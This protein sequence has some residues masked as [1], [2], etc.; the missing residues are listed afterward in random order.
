MSPA[1][2]LAMANVSPPRVV[3]V[4]PHDPAST[5]ATAVRAPKAPVI[6]GRADEAIWATAQVI[7]GFRVYDPSEDG[8][9]RFNTEARVA[10]DERNIYIVVRAF[11]PHPDS[12]G[13]LLSR[14]D[15]RTASDEIKV[16]IDSYHD[17][18][19]GF[20]F[21][22]NPA[23]VKRDIAIFNDSE[24]DVSW[25]AVWDA[26][27]HVDSQGWVAEFRI[28]L[29]QLRYAAKP[30]HTFGLAIAR[31]VARDNESYA[32][33]VYRRSKAGIASQFGELQGITGIASPRRL[34]VA[35]YTVAKTANVPN[36]P[37]AYQQRSVGTVGA[38]IKYGLTSNLTIDATVNPDFGQ[39]EADPSVLNLSAFESFFPEKRPFFLEGQGLFRFDMNCNDGQCSGMFYSRRIGRAPQLNDQYF[40]DANPTSTT[41]LGAGKLTGRLSNGMSVG[42]LNAVTQREVAP[43][44]KT[45]EP[46]AN[47][48]VGRVQQ[49]L[50]G[51]KSVVGIMATN[52]HRDQDPWTSDLL[53]SDATAI[54]IDTRHEFLDRRYS[55]SSYL[56]GTTVRGS[57]AAIALTQT[58]GV[59][60]YQRVEDGVAYDPSRTSLNGASGQVIVAKI[61]GGVTRFTTGYQ[62][63]SPGFE[64]N[65]VGFLSR[66]NARNQFLWYAVQLRKATKVYRQWFSNFNQW[67]NYTADG[68]RSELGGNVNSH[69]QFTNNWWIHVG[70]GGNAL[71]PSI[72]DNCSRGGPGVRQSRTLWG[73]GGLQGD[74]RHAIVPEIF[75]QW[76]AGDEGKS[77]SWS[78]DPNVQIK[79]ASRFS[80]DIGLSYG[81]FINDVQWYGNFGDVAADTTHYSFARL[82]Q[83][84]TSVTTR[85]NFTATPNLSLQVYA[86]PFMTGGDFSDWRELRDPRATLYSARY[87]PYD[88]SVID[89]STLADFNFRQYRSNTVVRWE[90]R[91]GSTLYFVWAQERTSSDDKRFNVGDDFGRLFAAHPGNVFLIKG[92]Y[93]TAF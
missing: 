53:R 84:V 12:I 40:D 51:G 70:Q 66:A 92:S 34:E 29:N 75:S 1:Q 69:M 38:D 35:P 81:H 6:D 14:R 83:R 77:H 89:G 73:W 33:P 17:K 42:V 21:A 86:Q 43:G 9:P 90:Y 2:Q 10:Y 41:I 15:V 27:A 57:A 7:S 37:T 72:C 56:A 87:Q 36:G 5:I 80:A 23:G 65:D 91:P 3:K 85:L 26:A 31:T 74:N 16:L 4:A 58:N 76:M 64:T 60:N 25:D 71:A 45:I 19:S 82:D 28:P 55:I 63:I 30:T 78:F 44:D 54:G 20:E 62:Y 22:I 52:V 79:V 47:Y 88:G 93:R 59:H 8:D 32:W 61:G 46:R 68:L 13:A 18:R 24:E 48:F 11:D 50:R 39:V 49:E 67:S